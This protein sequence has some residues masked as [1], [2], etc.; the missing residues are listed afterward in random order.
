MGNQPRYS[1][2]DT[3]AK[4]SHPSKRV[5]I[6]CP[7]SAAEPVPGLELRNRNRV[8]PQEKDAAAPQQTDMG[9]TA[10]PPK[11][12]LGSEMVNPHSEVGPP[13]GWRL[14]DTQPT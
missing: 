2:N 1:P 12:T 4:G 5:K 7:V 8:G 13:E 6:P 9:R 11:G 3:K 14:P 10:S